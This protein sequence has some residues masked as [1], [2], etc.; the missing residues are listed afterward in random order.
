MPLAQLISTG[1][2]DIATLLLKNDLISKT[3]PNV[4]DQRPTVGD[5]RIHFGYRITEEEEMNADERHEF[6][7]RSSAPFTLSVSYFLPFELIRPRRVGAALR[8]LGH[9]DVIR[10]QRAGQRVQEGCDVG[11]LIIGQ[12]AGQLVGGHHSDYF[13]Q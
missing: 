2:L 11:H 8:E 7:P 5:R 9:E 10:R 3:L 6:P 12:L 13:F 1:Q 4:D